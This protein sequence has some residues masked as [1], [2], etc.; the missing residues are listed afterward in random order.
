MGYFIKLIKWQNNKF[1]SCARH[2][3]SVWDYEIA[4]EWNCDYSLFVIDFVQLFRFFG[5]DIYSP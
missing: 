1:R 4:Y 3:Y 5:S 2:G